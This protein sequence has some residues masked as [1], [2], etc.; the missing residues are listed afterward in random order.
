MRT[1]MTLLALI[2]L[3][4]CGVQT[5]YVSDQTYYPAD[6]Q[7]SSAAYQS[8]LVGHPGITFNAFYAGVWATPMYRSSYYSTNRI[9]GVGYDPVFRTMPSYRTTSFQSTRIP[10]YTRSTYYS[11]SG[12]SGSSYRPTTYSSS[13]SYSSSRPSTS[14]TSTRR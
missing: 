12:S 10:S 8:Y 11:S 5:Q 6:Y 1:L 2:V 3:T 14:F 9:V 7:Y 13:S 4:S